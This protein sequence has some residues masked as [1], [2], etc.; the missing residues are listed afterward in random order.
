MILTTYINRNSTANSQN[1]DGVAFPILII[2]IKKVKTS[3]K[4]SPDN[5]SLEHMAN[6]SAVLPQTCHERSNARKAKNYHKNN[7]ESN[8]IRSVPILKFHVVHIHVTLNRRKL[9]GMSH[10]S[11]IAMKCY[12]SKRN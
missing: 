9:F 3:D 12:D 7:Q 8:A 4:Q 2:I 6:I 5:D 10:N 11:S 1:L